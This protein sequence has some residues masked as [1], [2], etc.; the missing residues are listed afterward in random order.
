M[1]CK[2]ELN[3][4]RSGQ[5]KNYHVRLP[6]ELVNTFPKARLVARKSIQRIICEAL[7]KEM[8]RIGLL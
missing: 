8:R 3:T 6:A 5:L 4:E 7:Q 2:G 1:I